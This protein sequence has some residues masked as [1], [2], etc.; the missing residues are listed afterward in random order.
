MK[1]LSI[2]AATLLVLAGLGFQARAQEKPKVQRVPAK[3]TP[4]DSG[5]T[6]FTNYCAPCHGPEGRGNGP[7]AAAL[8]KQPA[9]LTELSKKNGGKFPAATVSQF[10]EGDQVLPAHGSRD[11]PIWGNIFR[12]MDKAAGSDALPRLRIHNLTAYVESLQ[13][14]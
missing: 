13:G 4:V 1:C 9:N 8:K 10:I 7:A 11:M 3:N 12:S 14:K 2:S 6:M 5:A